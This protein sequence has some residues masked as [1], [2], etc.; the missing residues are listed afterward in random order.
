M[1]SLAMAFATALLASPV[2]ADF[3]AI[4]VNKKI[5]AWGTAFNLKTQGAAEAAALDKCYAKGSGQCQTAV[6]FEGGCGALALTSG[7]GA[8]GADKGRD[9]GEAERKALARCNSR[10]AQCEIKVSRCAD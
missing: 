5:G 3:G 8:W 1:R 7:G 2:A 6:W 10:G 9:K 4:A